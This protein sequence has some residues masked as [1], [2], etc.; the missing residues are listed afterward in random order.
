MN[1]SCRYRQ[2]LEAIGLREKELPGTNQ[3]ST[4]AKHGN[5][6]EVALV[7]PSLVLDVCEGSKGASYP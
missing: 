7:N 3:N 5:Q 4:E 1:V 6:G 2:A